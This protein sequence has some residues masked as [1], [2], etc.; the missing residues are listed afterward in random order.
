M[1]DRACQTCK[2]P[3]PADAAGGL[4]PLCLLRLALDG[5]REAYERDGSARVCEALQDTLTGGSAGSY[6][7][8]AEA[9]GMSEGAVKV[10]AHRLRRRF[11]RALRAE[12]AR[13]VDPG[14]VE[15][16]LRYLLSV[17]SN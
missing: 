14:E 6:R 7:A 16:E 1:T 11:G 15:D 12:V 3:I 13:T 4:C 9:L 17:L 10:A 5:V 2:K 8:L